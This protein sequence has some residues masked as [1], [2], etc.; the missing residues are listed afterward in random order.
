MTTGS[1]QCISTDTKSLWSASPAKRATRTYQRL[2]WTLGAAALTRRRSPVSASLFAWGS[3]PI[4]AT[5]TKSHTS[6]SSA[7]LGPETAGQSQPSKACETGWGGSQPL[8]WPDHWYDT[9]PAP[10]CRLYP[11]ALS[12]LEIL[13]II[14]F[15]YCLI[16]KEMEGMDTRLG[17]TA[18]CART[19]TR[20]AKHHDQT[21]L[22]W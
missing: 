3:P 18:W 15:I 11:T 12:D 9:M 4:L 1:R 17:T 22:C 21:Y 19:P 10:S 7:T 2:Q 8:C 14:S 16:T 5:R 13:L 20:H 6:C